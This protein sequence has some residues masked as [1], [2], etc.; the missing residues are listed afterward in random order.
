MFNAGVHYPKL[1]V[2]SGLYL[3]KLWRILNDSGTLPLALALLSQVTLDNKY[4]TLLQQPLYVVAVCCTFGALTSMRK[5]DNLRWINVVALI[6]SVVLLVVFSYAA[7]IQPDAFTIVW[8]ILSLAFV[9]VNSY[10]IKLNLYSDHQTSED[11]GIV[12]R[13]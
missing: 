9:V 2:S 13:D 3:T 8:T 5:L 4:L 12:D 6:M 11:D 10:H 7:Y 1:N